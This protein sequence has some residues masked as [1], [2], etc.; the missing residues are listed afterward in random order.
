MILVLGTCDELVIWLL[1]Q[2]HHIEIILM[3]M[4]V[5]GTKEANESPVLTDILGRRNKLVLLYEFFLLLL[6]SNSFLIL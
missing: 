3:L 1:Y 6:V 4:Q 5:D 2:F